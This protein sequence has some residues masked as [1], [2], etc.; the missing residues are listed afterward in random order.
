MLGLPSTHDGVQN[1]EAGMKGEAMADGV[2]WRHRASTRES[3]C[4]LMRFGEVLVVMVF[5]VE[6]GV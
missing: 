4:W 5:F 3:G 6:G 1:G 2:R